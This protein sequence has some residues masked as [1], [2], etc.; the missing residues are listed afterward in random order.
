MSFSKLKNPLNEFL[1]THKCGGG[2]A[3][4]TH[5]SMGDPRGKFKIGDHEYS[6]FYDL[7]VETVFKKKI[8]CYLT[9]KPDILSPI[10][11]DIDF[12]WIA[13]ENERI[14]NYDHLVEIVKLYMKQLLTYF[15][16]HN[17]KQ[18]HAY[19][20]EKETPIRTGK[21]VD[22][23][24]DGIH[25]MF[26]FINTEAF[27]EKKVRSGVLEMC[28]S[29][30]DSFSETL[31]NKYSDVIDS[32]VI[33]RN[34]W[35]M[36][37][38]R[39]PHCQAYTLTHIFSPPEDMASTSA[40]TFHLT[41][42][43][44]DD[45]VLEA[46]DTEAYTNRTL[47][48][49]LSIR[50]RQE[51]T[52]IKFEMKTKFKAELEKNSIDIVIKASKKKTQY[53]FIKSSHARAKKTTIEMVIKLVEIL[54]RY[55]SEEYKAWYELGLCLNHIHNADEILLKKWIEF[56]KKSPKYVTTAEKECRKYW[57][58]MEDGPINIATLRLWAQC[59][60][61][62][63][64]QKVLND[65]LE[66]E[67]YKSALGRCCVGKHTHWDIAQIVYKMFRNQFV[68]ASAKNKLWYQFYDH[69]WQIMDG[70]LGLKKK[71][72]RDVF[73]QY[74]LVHEKM[75]KKSW[76]AGDGAHKDAEKVAKLMGDLKNTSFKDNILKETIEFFHSVKGIFIKELDS[77]NYL[78][79]FENGVYDLKRDVFR[80]G[81]PEDKVSLSTEINYV[82]FDE[83]HYD[84]Q[85][86]KQFMKQ[87]LPDEEVREYVLYSL[88]SYLDGSTKEEK[89][90][91]WIGR[92]G[93]GK[94]L[95]VDMVQACMGQYADVIPITLLTNKKASST[96]ATPE[97]FKMKGKRFAVLQE[98]ESGAQIDAGHLKELT[99]GDK[100]SCRTLYR[101]PITFKP[102]F[103]LVMTCNEEPKLP[104][105]DGGIWRRVRAVHFK[106]SFVDTPS[107][108]WEQ[109]DGTILTTEEH[110]ERKKIGLMDI[111]IPKNDT[112]PEYPIDRDLKQISENEW[113]EP[114]MWYLL[115]YYKKYKKNGIIEPESVLEY[116]KN[117]QK[118]QDKILEF[119]DDY[120]EEVHDYNSRILIGEFKKEY[121]LWHKEFHE[122]ER[123]PNRKAIQL[124]LE[125]KWGPF[126]DKTKVKYNQR[127]WHYLKL[128][129]FVPESSGL[130]IEEEEDDDT[131]S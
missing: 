53:K 79:G 37:G 82:E 78:L 91:I 71:I 67:I 111:W 64:Y 72:S 66:V 115:Q 113:K 57:A 92:G 87:I 83:D 47:V 118:S 55:R 121:N 110:L 18:L 19:V 86:I 22:E 104:G 34:N 11:V 129:K 97:M 65:V 51:A 42:G 62:A 75:M 12:K 50:N 13:E 2:G 81:R 61:P 116:T 94:S 77:I 9:E 107:G 6:T 119:I 10:K 30:F 103:K 45:L 16:I 59:D 48:E 33:D 74:K 15:N 32:A 90:H 44:I 38:S 89:C 20:F 7:Y 84:I 60:N 131:S 25:I 124:R 99:G 106:S 122:N 63:E 8:K 31:A 35:Q 21:K 43:H 76:E 39:K 36:Y 112:Y 101:E 96:Q 80:E 54:D 93:N 28:D 128:K 56:S 109:E 40:D 70:N 4:F 127:G 100:I 14:Y 58:N 73:Q 17:C 123:C 108:H 98:P 41:P 68:C 105:G 125:K 130:M 126:Y 46:L 52:A 102:Q 1:L 117:Y 24:K 26:P 23:N 120:V 5:T 88:S 95:L 49:I 29:V 85:R 27:W 114:F 3:P 69:R